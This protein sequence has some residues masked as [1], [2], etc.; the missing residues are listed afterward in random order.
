MLNR[1]NFIC[2]KKTFQAYNEEILGWLGIGYVPEHVEKYANEQDAAVEKSAYA[3]DMVTTSTIKQP[4]NPVFFE[5]L[6]RGGN[7]EVEYNESHPF[8]DKV[9]PTGE[10]SAASQL[11]ALL[12]A[13]YHRAK[14]RL[15]DS[16]ATDASI[17]FGQLEHD[18]S[19]YLKEYLT[20]K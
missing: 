5:V 8:L 15:G 17:L 20:K 7:T 18:W 11:V 6:H 3:P 1:D 10:D 12:L 4:R 2:A 9:R 13:S 14:E 19:K 16:P